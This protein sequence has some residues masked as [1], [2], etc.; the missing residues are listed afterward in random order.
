MKKHI[1]SCHKC[2]YYKI[3]KSFPE[4]NFYDIINYLKKNTTF[5][6]VNFKEETVNKTTDSTEKENLDRSKSFDESSC[7]IDLSVVFTL[8][9]K[10]LLMQNV[11]NICIQE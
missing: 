5:P 3:I 7:K 9:Q 10:C 1:S 8:V 2:N 11:L 4:R 6:F